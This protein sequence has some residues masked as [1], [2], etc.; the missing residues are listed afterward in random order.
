MLWA[1]KTGWIGLDIGEATVKAAQVVR[2]ARRWRLAAT[3]IVPRQ[4]AWP[5]GLN[6]TSPSQSSG[7]E[8]AAARTLQ[9]DFQ[10]RRVA[11][12]LPMTVCD[13]HALDRS[14]DGDPRATDVVRR[15]LETAHQRSAEDLEFDY[16]TSG[17]SDDAATPPWTNVLCVARSWS[18]QLVEDVTRA[19]WSCE[20]IDGLPLALAR[21]VRLVDDSAVGAPVAALDWGHGRAT[22]CVTV[23]GRPAYVRAL[24]NC[25]LR[26]MLLRLQ[27]ELDLTQ[28]E[29][30][31][32]LEQQGLPDPARPETDEASA[33]LGQ[34]V[35]D[36]LARLE[37]ELRRSLSHFQYQRRAP[38]PERLYLFGGGATVARLP[39][40]L[41][42]RLRLDAR[43]WRLEDGAPPGGHAAC[44]FGQAAALSAL[45]WEAR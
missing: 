27:E 24:K 5:E 7:D 44:L 18:D 33:L 16:W 30:Q 37:D 8:V 3:A 14:V 11:A 35:A 32:M 1:R 23:D 10:G 17:Q 12:A 9:P 38:A 45:A 41:A 34:L 40:V 28:E 25:G 2:H 42:D 20:T 31:A 36:P 21:A 4:S 19:G 39:A 6:L 15:A 22:L 43:V 26:E 29:A 13:L